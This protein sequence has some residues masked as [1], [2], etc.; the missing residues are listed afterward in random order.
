MAGK[1]P[2]PQSSSLQEVSSENLGQIQLCPLWTH[3]FTPLI[4]GPIHHT[5]TWTNNIKKC[6][7]FF[8]GLELFLCFII[9]TDTL[10]IL[11]I[12]F[13]DSKES[14]S[15][16]PKPCISKAVFCTA[17]FHWQA[18]FFIPPLSGKCWLKLNEQLSAIKGQWWALPSKSVLNSSCSNHG[19][20]VL[21]TDLLAAPR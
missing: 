8:R 3:R 6:L 9:V 4:S 16:F 10:W 21:G 11:T 17:Q 19:K 5:H 15:V 13:H 2:T 1:S 20:K 7:V 14:N 12:M 18:L